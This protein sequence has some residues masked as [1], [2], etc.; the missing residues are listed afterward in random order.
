MGVDPQKKAEGTF[1]SPPS[2]P[3]SPSPLEVGPLNAAR[4]F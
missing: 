3:F 1:P 4:R 2:T